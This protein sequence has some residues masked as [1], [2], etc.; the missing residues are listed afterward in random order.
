[1]SD[2]EVEAHIDEHELESAL[3]HDLLHGDFT[4]NQFVA[5]ARKGNAPVGF[6][7]A[8]IR[9]EPFLRL[10]IG[11]IKWIYVDPEF[12]REGVSEQLIGVAG[13]WMTKQGA[14]GRETS[15]ASNNHAGL[16]LWQ[17]VGF[18]VIEHRLGSGKQ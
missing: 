15:V 5:A 11:V 13:A 7:L 14:R 3:W 12:R 1:M 17:T 8:E 18:T 4:D 9:M 10:P 6:I 16:A 2:D